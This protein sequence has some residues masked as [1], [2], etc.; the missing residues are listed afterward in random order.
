MAR[1]RRRFAARRRACGYSQEAFAQAVGVERTTVTRWEAADTEPQ[2]WYR[3]RIAQL[4]DVSLEELDDL[5]VDISEAECDLAGTDLS[6]VGVGS[7]PA[8]L[9]V[10][11]LR[12]TPST[13][14]LLS[15]DSL[16][17]QVQRSWRLRQQADYE[18][19]AHQL[20]SLIARGEASA[21]GLHEAD[22]EQAIRATVHA[23]NAAS[24]LLKTLGDCHF[25]LV[26]ADRAVQHAEQ[27]DDPLLTAAAHYRVANVLL[28]AQRHD[29]ATTVALQAA[30]LVTPG[31]KSKTR[32]LA[33]WGGLQL[34]AAVAYART[35]QETEAWQS[36]GE[37]HAVSRMLATDHAD[38]YCI[39]GPTNLAIHGVQIAAELGDGQEA[40][41]RARFVDPR[42]LPSTLRERRGQF[43]IDLAHAHCLL[44]DDDSTVAAL[45]QAYAAAPQEVRLSRL[46]HRVLVTVLRRAHGGTRA[47]LRDFAA[48]V[49]VESSS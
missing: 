18:A 16:A 44:R 49:G 19:L 35:G 12:P 13:D 27:L 21:K 32:G 46:A 42:R 30:D 11:M 47:E 45:S 20:P 40:V 25:G 31:A 39:F 23:Y 26:A 37:A 7:P 43:L 9:V 6:A 10:S 28:S 3:R 22:R 33:T 36:L 14:Q 8:A 38:I 1:K 4:L 2:P 34:T 15:A 24:S 17:M 48:A 41:R 29:E 5:L